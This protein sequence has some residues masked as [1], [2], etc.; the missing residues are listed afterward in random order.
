[1]FGVSN[2]FGRKE[3]SA[4]DSGFDAA[5]LGLDRINPY[6]VGTVDHSNGNGGTKKGSS[7]SKNTLTRQAIPMGGVTDG[8]LY[9]YG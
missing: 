7:S 9:S 2:M 4:N 8:P 1:M 3:T 5:F 6:P